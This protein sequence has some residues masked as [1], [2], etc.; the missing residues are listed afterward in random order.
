MDEADRMVE[1]NF[2]GFITQILDLMQAVPHVQKLGRLC[3]PRGAS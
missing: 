2:E 1:A 3:G